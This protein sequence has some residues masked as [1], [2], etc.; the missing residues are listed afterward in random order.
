M[1]KKLYSILGTVFIISSGFLYSFERFIAYYGWI[2]TLNSNI[3]SHSTSPHL[4]GIFT[5]IFIP[6]FLIIGFVLIVK[7]YKN[8][9]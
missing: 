2:G 8:N 5:N 1:D 7:G 6:I 4:P 9:N 3:G